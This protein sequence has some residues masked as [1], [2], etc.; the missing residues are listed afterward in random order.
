M[1]KEEFFKQYDFY[2]KLDIENIEKDKQKRDF[3]MVCN[4]HDTELLLF[5]HNIIDEF[6]L[7]TYH[8]AKFVK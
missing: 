8:D 6:R 7:L 4:S 2:S 1:N 3:T 5:D